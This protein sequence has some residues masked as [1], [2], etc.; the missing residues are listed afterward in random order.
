MSD[1]P[2]EQSNGRAEEKA[3]DDGKI[4]RG[5][6]AAVDDVAW[7][8]TEAEGESSAEVKKRAHDDKEPAEN[9]KRA[10]KFAEGIHR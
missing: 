10:A 3:G 1:K 5:V 8:A 9:E 7:K 2:E 6:F 4:E